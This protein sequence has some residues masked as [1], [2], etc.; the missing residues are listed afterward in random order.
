MIDILMEWIPRLP[1]YAMIVPDRKRIE[2]VLKN[3]IDNAAAFAC[4]VL[5]DSHD[6]VQGG[7]AGFTIMSLLSQDHVSD[8]VFMFVLPE[9][10]N[11]KNSNM[12]LEAYKD[13]AK[14]RGAKLIR[15]SHTGGSFPEGSK[16]QKM[17]DQLLKRHGFLPVGTIYHLNID[18]D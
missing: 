3:N 15:A 17:F 7:G 10:R 11:L 16:E 14:A 9:F 6:V 8:D 1:N 18:G 12:L 2:Y 4:W 13:W 5:C